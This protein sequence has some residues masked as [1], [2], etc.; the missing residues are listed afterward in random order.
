M[1]VVQQEHERPRPMAG[2][3]QPP[4]DA[5]V[6]DPRLTVLDHPLVTTLLTTLRHQAPPADAFA[7]A[8]NELTRFTLWAAL[9]NEPLEPVRVPSPTG[10]EAPGGRLANGLALV[11]IAR[12]GL[13]MLVAARA[14][15]PEA[16]FYII[17]AH[18]DEQTL[19][20][21]ILF[22]SLPPS[23]QGLRHILLLDP[24]LATGGSAVAALRHL[25]QA[26]SG[27][28]TYLGIIGA[29]YGVQQVLNADATVRIV[30]AALD[31]RLNDQGF[32]LPGLGDAGDRLFATIPI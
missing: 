22:T 9:A 11:A 32:I 23:Y 18:R 21:T 7:H 19:E 15:L 31:D 6:H 10:L 24:M 28:I 8:L 29:P 12:A 14:L 4:R 20:P 27:A 2:R 30:L 16:P 1:M 5:V 13:G 17:G 26:F 3:E 25:R